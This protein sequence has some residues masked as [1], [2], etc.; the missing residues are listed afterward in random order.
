MLDKGPLF[1]ADAKAAGKQS[2]LLVENHN[3]RTADI[4]LMQKRLTELVALQPDFLLYYYYPV[5]VAEPDAA[6][7]AIVKGLGK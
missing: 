7:R 1:L 3:L 6:M 4:G 5:D 2:L